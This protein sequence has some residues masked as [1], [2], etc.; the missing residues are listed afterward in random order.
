MIEVVIVAPE[1]FADEISDLLLE[2]GALS[3]SLLDADVDTPA[4]VP[5]FGEPGSFSDD[6]TDISI[7]TWNKN[8]LVALLEDGADVD[9]LIKKLKEKY[10]VDFN[11]KVQSVPDLDWVPLTQSQFPPIQLAEK[12][13][14]VPSWHVD[15]I[16]Q[17]HDSVVIN[18]DPGLAFGTGSHATTS[19]CAEW[20][21]SNNVEDKSLLDYGCGSG[22]LAIIAKKY[23]AN[24]VVGVDIDEQAVETAKLNSK[25]NQTEIEFYEPNEFPDG[26]YDIVIANIL[27]NPLKLLAPMLSA[28]VKDG[29]NLVLSGILERQSEGLI[30]IYSEFLPM[31]VWKSKDGWVCLSGVKDANSMH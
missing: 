20:I 17:A 15:N 6:E 18:L 10:D 9:G 3:V 11:Y 13:W 26:Q 23:K 12:L 21:Y 30:D 29:G 22:I 7:K 8:N 14:I 28:R 2:L 1:H 4:E 25:Q 16:N 24:P 31:K 27:S 5:V 19:L